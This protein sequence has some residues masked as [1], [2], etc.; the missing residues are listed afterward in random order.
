MA[1]QLRDGYASLMATIQKPDRSDL[2]LGKAY[3]EMGRLLMAAEY[4]EAAEHCFLNAQALVPTDA[5][6]PYYL[7]HLYKTWATRPKSVASFRA[8]GPAAA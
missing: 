7:A 5:R 4:R 2:E 8:R 6:W 3:G 1:E